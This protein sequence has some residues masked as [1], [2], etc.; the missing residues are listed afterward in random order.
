MQLVKRV[1][2]ES[3]LKHGLFLVFWT[4]LW[5]AIFFTLLVGQERLRTSDLSEQFHAFAL[6][7]AREWGA[8][9]LPLWSPGSYG[10]FPFVADPQSGSFYWPRLLTILLSPGETLAFYALELEALLHI[11]AAGI[12][13]YIFA[14][15]ETKSQ[16]AAGVA[17]IGFGLSGYLVGYPIMQLAILETI[18]W[19]PLILFTLHRLTE[20]GSGQQR[21]R[22]AVAGAILLAT[23]ATAGHPQTFMHLGYLVVAYLF[24]RA[25]Q[26]KWSIGQTLRYLLLLALVGGALSSLTWLPAA[27]YT[28]DSN[29]ASVGYSFTAAGLPLLELFQ[30]I[31]P[32]TLSLWAP[33]YTGMVIVVLALAALFHGGQAVR[34]WGLVA[35]ISGWL[36]LG[37]QGILFELMYRLAPGL[38][39]FRQQERWLSIFTFALVLLGAH[40]A[41]ALPRLERR[42]W[43]N[44]GTTLAILFAVGVLILAGGQAVRPDDWL[45]LV[46]R[47]LLF[48]AVAILALRLTLKWPRIWLVVLSFLAIDLYL[49]TAP[50]LGREQG[51]PTIYWPEP[52]W[53]GELQATGSRLDTN[54]VFWSNFGEIYGL[55]DLAGISPLKPADLERIEVLPVARRWRLLGITHFVGGP[56]PDGVVAD[57]LQIVGGLKPTDPAEVGL[58]YALPDPIPATRVVYNVQ[59][60]AEWE[61]AAAILANDQFDLANS[62]LLPDPIDLPSP[63]TEAA[64]TWQILSA[65]PGELRLQVDSPAPGIL[66]T[67]QWYYRG[68]KVT[69][70]GA[71]AALLKANHL[72][73][74]VQIPAGASSVRFYYQPPELYVAALLAAGAGLLALWLTLA[75]GTLASWMGRVPALPD[76]PTWRWG[77]RPSLLTAR[78]DSLR[79]GLARLSSRQWL[80]L[81]FLLAFF[82]RLETA[83]T[84]NLRGDE[85][86]TIAIV[87]EPLDA[88]IPALKRTNDPHPPLHYFLTNV[89]LEMGGRSELALRLSS[90]WLSLLLLAMV[91][92]LGREIAGRN[93]AVLAALLLA[94]AQSMVWLSQDLRNQYLLALLFGLWATLLL[95]RQQHWWLYSIASVLT[96]YS[97]Y[98]G[99]FL[100]L[101][102]GIY[103]LMLPER[104]RLIL[105]WLA[106][107]GAAAL[108]F[109]PWLLFM[110]QNTVTTQLSTPAAIDL[111]EHLA[112]VGVELSVGGALLG[113]GRR[114]LFLAGLL[115]ALWSGLTWPRLPRRQRQ[116]GVWL[117]SWLGITVLGLYLIRLNRTIYNNFYAIM[118]APA[119][120]LLIAAAINRLLTTS[121]DGHWRKRGLGLSL[122]VAFVVSNGLSLSNYFSDTVTFGRDRGYDELANLIAEQGSSADLIMVNAPDPSLGYYLHGLSQDQLLVPA[123]PGLDEAA[124]NEATAAA[125]NAYPRTWFVPANGGLLDPSNAV[126]RWLDYHLLHE[127]Y[128]QLESLA[129]RAYRPV[130]S[131]PE[132]AYSLDVQWADAIQLQGV[133]L[134]LNGQLL[135]GEPALTLSPGDELAVTLIWAAA[136]DVPDDYVV[137]VHLLSDSGQLLA[138]HDGVPLF[139]TRPTSTWQPGEQLLDRHVLTLADELS[140]QP[141]RLVAG[142]YSAA[143]VTR[144]N[145]A[146][147]ATEVAIFPGDILFR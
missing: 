34:F 6:F 91:A 86:F 107:A 84:Q 132:V 57:P 14:Y 106:A 144:L 37:D 96:M 64:P 97:H 22:W 52:A 88:I 56:P 41:L 82:L 121:A 118:A 60:A 15:R 21:R 38:Q 48:G 131:A 109:L 146:T 69:I 35:L 90:I 147:G 129:L 119:W 36:A 117:L 43:Y 18:V 145:T 71:P 55:F 80:L 93:S 143:T 103:L 81:I 65:E 9:R 136:G 24:W 12:F 116:A 30:I 51:S 46:G 83:G 10:G 8:G 59:V 47:Q 115:L 92:R 95:W 26:N 100:L 28:L 31:L 111:G 68:W 42:Q 89:W 40:G 123:E 75:P 74:A 140:A 62:V 113:S 32:N 141:A 61:E 76:R 114:W 105:R 27:I 134:T 50:G 4:V 7:Q 142:L 87:E 29:R 73:Q 138:Q 3:N 112:R 39:L 2:T 16:A 54:N 11:W 104:R 108:L 110:Y 101:S 98:F 125:I 5:A 49:A 63:A 99:L 58:L 66:L 33:E 139:G 23:A 133:H 128:Y 137:F 19:L 77:W 102:H 72:F 25:R 78:L 70:D 130:Y 126:A 1:E 67:G 135:D 85:A 20:A 44:A 127:Q 124:I 94:V 13:T 122:L 45:A 120:W 17:A 79:L 53:I